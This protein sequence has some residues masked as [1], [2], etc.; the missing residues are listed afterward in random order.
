MADIFP[1]GW[2]GLV[3]SGF[4]PATAAFD[5]VLLSGPKVRDRMLAANIL[6]GQHAIV[7]YLVAGADS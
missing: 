5:L 1:T 6:G 7:G 3:L 2:H 4:Q